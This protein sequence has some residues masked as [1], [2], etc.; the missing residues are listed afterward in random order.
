MAQ[1]GDEPFLRSCESGARLA[2]HLKSLLKAKDVAKKE[3]ATSTAFCALGCLPYAC[4]SASEA[5]TP[6]F[7]CCLHTV[8]WT[9]IKTA[10]KVVAVW[11]VKQTSALCSGDYSV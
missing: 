1:R 6:R 7:F 8:P 5:S 2:T 11:V 9:N 3:S 10:T 4:S